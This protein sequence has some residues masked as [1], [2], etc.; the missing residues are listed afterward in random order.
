MSFR[1]NLPARPADEDV[2]EVRS[3][4]DGTLVL[5][6]ATDCGHIITSAKTLIEQSRLPRDRFDPDEVL[7]HHGRAEDKRQSPSRLVGSSARRLVGG[8]R[9]AALCI[10][11]SSALG[12][13]RRWPLHTPSGRRG[14]NVVD[15]VV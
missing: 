5:L 7:L 2:A 11:H 15:F 14:D 8:P 10:V 13:W 12:R 1:P 4:D 3:G 6:V 9:G